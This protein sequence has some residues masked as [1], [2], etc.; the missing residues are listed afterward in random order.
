MGPWFIR[1]DLHPY[2]PGCSYETIR[3]L[4][5]RGRLQPGSILRG[6]GTNQFWCLAKRTPGIAHLLGLCH[7]C[8]A[9]ARAEEI[10]CSQCG[11]SF[12]ADSDRQHLGLLA[13]RLLPGQAPAGIIAAAS[14]P[15]SAGEVAEADAGPPAHLPSAPSRGAGAGAYPGAAPDP[16]ASLLRRRRSHA[17]RRIAL[18]LIELGAIAAAYWIGL[19]RREGRHEAAGRDRSTS[20]EVPLR[21]P[22]PE[23]TGAKAPT[24]GLDTPEQQEGPETEADPPAAPLTLWEQLDPLLQEDSPDS[25]ATAR[26]IV[27]KEH[28]QGRLTDEA[29]DQLLAVL[30]RRETLKQ[31]R[32]LP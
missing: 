5:A 30:T 20:R 26:E 24:Q 29:R 8:Q 23:R 19:T 22:E 9:P 6:P 25:L 13:T 31:A 12:H 4:A 1:D 21:A 27:R 11:A 16:L 18:A 7:N 32:E 2:R 17:P 28:E 14:T 3:E 10:L 15:L